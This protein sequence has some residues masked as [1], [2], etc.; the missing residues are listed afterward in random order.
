MLAGNVLGPVL[1]M[2][3]DRVYERGVLAEGRRRPTWR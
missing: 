3:L 2:S 1:V